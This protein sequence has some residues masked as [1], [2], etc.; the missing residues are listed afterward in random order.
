MRRNIKE[1]N[2]PTAINIPSEIFA[3]RSDVLPKEKRIIVYCNTGG[4]SYTAYRKLMK[5]ACPNIAQT[6]F[7]EWKEAGMAVEK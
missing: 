5:L 1:G 3:S 4:R 2:I 6:Y 7:A